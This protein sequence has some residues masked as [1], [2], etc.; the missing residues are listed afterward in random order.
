MEIGKMQA[1][2][3]VQNT[4]SGV[5]RSSSFLKEGLKEILGGSINLVCGKRREALGSI[6][7]A[8]AMLGDF[9]SISSR[10]RNFLFGI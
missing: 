3:F 8:N 1:G 5:L 4:L 10:K 2:S 6:N 9:K 7:R